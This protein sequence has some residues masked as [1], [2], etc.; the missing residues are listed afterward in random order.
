MLGRLASCSADRYVMCPCL[1]LVFHSL[2]PC[3]VLR[4]AKL[5]VIGGCPAGACETTALPRLFRE[6][7]LCL[8]SCR[9]PVLVLFCACRPSPVRV[10]LAAT[11]S[12]LSSLSLSLCPSVLS[13]PGMFRV[14][15]ELVHTSDVGAKGVMKVWIRGLADGVGWEIF[16]YSVCYPFNFLC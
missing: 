1:C 4:L 12:V 10:I 7:E 9:S 13:V 6:G 2:R 16:H 3:A 11:S 5:S 14:F 8:G 15:Q